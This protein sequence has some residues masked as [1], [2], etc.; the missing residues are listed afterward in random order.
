MLCRMVGVKLDLRLTKEGLVLHLLA[1]T[2]AVP[3]CQVSHTLF[4]VLP[5]MMFAWVVV[6]LWF[7]F[8]VASKAGL[9]D[10]IFMGQG[11]VAFDPPGG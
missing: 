2:L 1:G 7:T 6:A 11:V 8:V 9:F 10:A 3:S 5:P 4:A